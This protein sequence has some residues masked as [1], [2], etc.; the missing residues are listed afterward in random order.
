MFDFVH[1]SDTLDC[2][3]NVGSTR[4]N[5]WTFFH[6]YDLIWKST[7]IIFPILERAHVYLAN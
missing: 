2:L 7:L 3:I 6:P 1:N 4:I 5:F